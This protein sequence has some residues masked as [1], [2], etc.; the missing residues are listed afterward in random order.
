[1]PRDG[2]RFAEIVELSFRLI[3]RLCLQR[4][5]EGVDAED[6]N[7]DLWGWRLGTEVDA[8][9]MAG[10]EAVGSGEMGTVGDV[11]CLPQRLN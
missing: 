11:I 2:C 6:S 7:G 10:W 1:M 8:E 3:G 5:E 4:E 9:G